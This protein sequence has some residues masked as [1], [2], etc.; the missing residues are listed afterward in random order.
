MAIWALSGKVTVS[1]YTKVEAETLEEA[2][3]ISKHREAGIEFNGAGLEESETWLVDDVD[4]EVEFL[5]GE[6][7]D[8]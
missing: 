8:D 2:I 5:H 1:A 3:E 7:T 4:G 6:E